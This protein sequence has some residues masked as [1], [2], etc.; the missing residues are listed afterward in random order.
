MS[1]SKNYCETICDLLNESKDIVN[2]QSLGL[3]LDNILKC[4]CEPYE[5][6]CY[7]YLPSIT[8]KGNFVNKADI[9]KQLN[10]NIL[11]YNLITANK[12]K[13]LLDKLYKVHPVDKPCL[14]MS[15]VIE[16]K[17]ITTRYRYIIVLQRHSRM[18]SVLTPSTLVKELKGI[19]DVI[20]AIIDDLLK[21]TSVED[22]KYVRVLIPMDGDRLSLKY[23]CKFNQLSIEITLLNVFSIS[24]LT[25]SVLLNKSF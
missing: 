16:F 24:L 1:N 10:N 19:G 4:T 18:I 25:H 15:L 13:E 14:P 2:I 23:V 21:H 5:D 8:I 3:K 9:Y 22:I 11:V 7:I 20:N 17:T 12:V 6:P